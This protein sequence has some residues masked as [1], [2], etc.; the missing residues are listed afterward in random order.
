MAGV[1]G[2]SGGARSGAGRKSKPK[3][4]PPVLDVPAGNDPLTFL[5]GVMN[6]AGADARLRVRAAVAAAQYVHAKQG[7]GGKKDAAERAA[8]SAAAGKFAPAAPPRLVV[9]NSKR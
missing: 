6:D 7:E 1:K 5:L 3:A 9:N 8:G 2:R 4:P